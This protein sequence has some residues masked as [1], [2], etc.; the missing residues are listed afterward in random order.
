MYNKPIIVFEGIDCS[1]KSLHT[2]NAANY[3]KKK[4]LPFI[5]IR[6]PGGNKNSE[7][8]RKL[9]LNKK[10]NFHKLTDLFLYF[11]SRNEN[12]NKVIKKN[13]QK[14]IILIDRFIDSTIAYQHYGM[15][16][17]K[18]LIKIIN[19]Y[20]LKDIKINF[21]FLNIVN[22]KN[23]KKRL[24]LRKKLNRYDRFNIK[25]YKNVQKGFLKISKNN[26]KYLIINSN[27]NVRDNKKQV[28][29]KLKEIII[30]K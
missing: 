1:G 7:Q 3:L 22:E 27:K 17:N 29:N 25:F 11:A 10:I 26:K 5:S 8:I 19:N 6:E 28:I 4:K 15:Q 30:K 9:I 14:K 2:K 24:S 16:I 21:T 20:L 12:I 13:Y 18:Q 23:L